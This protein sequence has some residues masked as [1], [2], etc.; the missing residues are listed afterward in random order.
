M[1]KQEK[2]NAMRL[3]DKAHIEY[4]IYSYESDGVAKDG[5]TVAG[6]IGEEVSKIYK[7]LVTRAHSLGYYIFVIP[8]ASELDLKKAALAA[9]EKSLDMIPVKDLLKVTG[10][11]RGG[12]SPIGMK[13]A[14]PTIID[15]SALDMDN[16]IVSAGKIGLQIELQPKDLI[17]MA[18]AAV[19]GVTR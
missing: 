16:I 15:E 4:N 7:T 10:Y 6:L 17:N 2:T 19:Y 3:L 14:F 8:A 11:V 1:S 12:C 13:K 18:N 9:N 5:V